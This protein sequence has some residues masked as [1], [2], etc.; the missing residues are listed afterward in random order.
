M[1]FGFSGYVF[2][3]HTNLGGIDGPD[4]PKS[5]TLT[6]S[7]TLGFYSRLMEGKL[8]LGSHVTVP[9]LQEVYLDYSI[10]DYIAYKTAPYPVVWETSAVGA[11]LNSRLYFSLKE[12][13]EIYTS[14]GEDDRRGIAARTI[15]ALEWWP[16][17][18]ISLRLGGEYDFLFLMDKINHGFGILGG[19]TIRRRSFDLDVNYTLMQRTLRFYPGLTAPDGTLLVQASWNGTWI[20]ERN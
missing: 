3:S 11:A 7:V 6:A 15:P 10:K 17:H 19:L 9:F 5:N 1:A 14:F 12:I 20:K 13:A 8:T 4:D 16:A 2:N 18:F